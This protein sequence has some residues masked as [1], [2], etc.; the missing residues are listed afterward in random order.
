MELANSLKHEMKSPKKRRVLSKKSKS[1]LFVWGMLALPLLQFVIFWLIPNADS[2]VMAFQ[3][4]N[5]DGFTMIN[6]SRFNTELVKEESSLLLSIKNTL[7]YFGVHIFIGLPV[8]V[9]MSY[10]LFKKVPFNNFFRVVF[11]L[12][13]IVGGM[14][15]ASLFRYTVSSGGPVEAILDGLGVAYD[16]QLGL[17]GNPQTVF[18][19]CIVYSL[20][21]GVGINMIM[22]FGA[23]NRIPKE[24]FES[25]KIDGAGFWRQFLQ[26][27]VPLIWPTI[28]TMLIF[29]M[30]SIFTTYAPVMLLAPETP[31]ASMIGWYIIRYTM[32]GGNSASNEVLNYPAAV[33]LIFTLIGFPLTLGVKWLCEKIGANVE[34]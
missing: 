7:I 15:T 9:F 33:G 28:T 25:A 13:S 27:V 21:V 3:N 26:I 11:Y 10:V 34:Y 23:M 12:P 24:I 20:W 6:F 2:F 18:F 8:V 22:F 29:L 19:M 32:A 16:K 14:V 1:L 4:P 5:V 31:E 17:L 30:A